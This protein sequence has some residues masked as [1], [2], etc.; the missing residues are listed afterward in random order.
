MATVVLL[1][2]SVII[3]SVTT[4]ALYRNHQTE[5]RRKILQHLLRYNNLVIKD[6]EYQLSKLTRVQIEEARGFIKIENGE[7]SKVTRTGLKA[8]TSFLKVRMLR[9]RNIFLSPDE[10]EEWLGDLKEVQYRLRYIEK[11]SKWVIWL[12]TI[13]QHARFGW[14]KLDIL[15]SNL[16]S[17]IIGG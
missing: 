7:K 4:L 8:L 12:Y 6:G 14:S 3:V 5:E 11:R 9:L 16:V 10:R 17:K 2:L 15:V 13:D 1:A